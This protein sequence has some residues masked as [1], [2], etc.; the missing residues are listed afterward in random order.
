MRPP[1]KPPRPENRGVV[2]AQHGDA[3]ARHRNTRRPASFRHRRRRVNLRPLHPPPD[4]PPCRFS[5]TVARIATTAS[6]RSAGWMKRRHARHAAAAIPSGNWPGS[7]NRRPA[8]RAAR[9]ARRCRAAPPARRVRRWPASC[10]SQTE[11]HIGLGRALIGATGDFR[12]LPGGKN[13]VWAVDAVDL[14]DRSVNLLSNP[15]Q[16]LWDRPQAQAQG[17]RPDGWGCR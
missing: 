15:G 2:P 3:T 4:R 10:D 6:R 7:P 16:P 9:P 12:P 1:N 13:P 8:A 14:S 11:R 17:E 5:P